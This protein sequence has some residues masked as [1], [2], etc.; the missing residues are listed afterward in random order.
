MISIDGLT[1]EFGVKPLFKDVSF[2]INERDRIA[3]VGKNGA[4]KS[5][6][7]KI[8][9]GM[10][11][12]TSGV[13]SVPNDTT[14]GYL[15]QVMK[16][17][18]DTTV[19]EETRKAFADKTKIEERLKKMEQEMAERTDYESEGYAELVE[20][21]TTEHERYMMMGGE[22]YEAEIER[23]L[24]GLGFSRDD[25]E[26]PTREFSGGWRMRI[27]LAKILLRRPDV[28]L[29][30]EPTNH[31]DIESIQWLEQFL[32]QSAKA[33]VLVS[34]DRAFVNNVT[35]RTLEITCGHVEDYR[36]KY[37]EYLVLRKERREQQ[38]RAYENQQKEIADTKA[39]IERFRYQATKAVQ[40]QQRIRQLE[41]IVPIEV[42]EVDNSA[43][44]LKFPPCLR[45]GDYPV[46]AEGLGKT[47]PS[48]LHSDGPGQ[49][50]FEGVDLII[51]R[52]EK[53]AFVGKN[54]EGKSTFVK[55]IMGEIPF[56]GTLK[57]GHNV[58]IGYFAQNQ[59]Q[60]LDENLTIYETIDRVATGDMR[61]RIND[62]LGAFMFGGETSEKYVKVLSGGER[63]R[64]AMIKLLLEP[65]NLLILDEPTNHL[66]IASKEVLKEAIKAFDGTAIIVS[67][68]REFLD[69]LV[70][71]VYEFGGGKVREHLGGI[72]DWLKSPL[73][74]PRKGESAENLSLT[75]SKSN[76]NQNASPLPSEGSGEASG[77]ALSYA[78][79]KEQ[80]KKI[81]KAQRA[82]DES[83]AKIAKL[84][85]HK[86]E[87]DELL[88]APENASNMELVTEYTNLQRE[89][90]EENE[91]WL[92]L[93]EELETL[94][95]EH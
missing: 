82:V 35:N 31:L 47:Y 76:N 5:T 29:L 58:Q 22:N 24:T 61:L 60:L 18:D 50:V 73:Q 79:R 7:L 41:K 19:K 17:S 38:L 71:K 87:L 40:V 26:R 95:I 53:V 52:G 59:A 75:S 3:L 85:A 2:V 89:L 94:N 91:R 68:D 21:F 72:Y 32:S 30:D 14:I 51:K 23:T 39:F 78:E 13:V 4:G 77:E 6:M 48:R 44:R 34:H 88:M 45:S 70:S 8:L 64:L 10:Q 86:G 25:F 74:L 27:E 92:I 83:E 63:S 57:I 67:H 20:R 49:T 37:D 15:P 84:E 11:K 80:Q 65:V 66:D 36:V 12:P 33:V 9:C 46:I 90:D 69:G 1:V 28:L 62:L 54:G 42:D 56:D 16:L 43:M 93:S 55:C 81:R